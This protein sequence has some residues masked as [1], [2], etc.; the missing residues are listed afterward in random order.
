MK[1]KERRENRQT[2]YDE[3]QLIERGKSYELGFVCAVL[4]LTIFYFLYRISDITLSAPFVIIVC[5]TISV[6]VCEMRMILTDSWVTSERPKEY[7]AFCFIWV[8]LLVLVVIVPIIKKPNL[9]EF[10]R[11]VATDPTNAYAF[12]PAVALNRTVTYVTYYIKLYRDK[13]KLKAEEEENKEE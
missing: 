9:I 8:L 6:T 3:R 2:F 4:L 5:L 7:L 12:A 1:N 11:D 13:K 10:L